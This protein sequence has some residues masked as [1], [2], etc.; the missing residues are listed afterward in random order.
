MLL[1]W[2]DQCHTETKEQEIH[3]NFNSHIIKNS[4]VQY[5]HETCFNCCKSNY[6]P[7]YKAFVKKKWEFFRTEN[8]YPIRTHFRS[9]MSNA[10][11]IEKQ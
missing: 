10:I 3:S 7:T 11:G 1:V 2:L 4:A 5:P 9:F 6:W 8:F